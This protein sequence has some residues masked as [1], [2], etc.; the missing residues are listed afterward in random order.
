MAQ[1]KEAP[2]IPLE[3]RNDLLAY[4]AD[5]LS[6]LQSLAEKEACNDL[7]LLLEQSRTEA[8]RQCRRQVA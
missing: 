7:A 4:I 6:E 8:L 2:G 3:A 5:L 1:S